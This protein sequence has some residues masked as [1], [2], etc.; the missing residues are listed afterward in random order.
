MLTFVFS[1]GILAK[2]SR[3]GSGIRKQELKKF[4]KKLKKVLDKGKQLSYTKQAVALKD[5]AVST[6]KIEQCKN[7]KLMLNKHQKRVLKVRN[8]YKFF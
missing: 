5:D 7:K 1:G 4:S 2:H 6:L 3:E 8:D